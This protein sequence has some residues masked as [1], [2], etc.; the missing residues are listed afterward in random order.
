MASE[1]ADFLKLPLY[2]KVEALKNMLVACATGGGSDALLYRHVRTELM[3]DE[4]LTSLTPRLVRT[5]R[6]PDEFWQFIMGEFSTYAERREFL[7]SEFDPILTYLE[8][9]ANGPLS[10]TA[11][12]ALKSMTDE[13]VADV[14]KR[15]LQRQDTDP[16]GAITAA[17]TLVETV[18][19]HV[20]DD[21]SE[22]YGDAADL[23]AL[24]RSV[25][26][27]LNLAPD[28]HTEQ[29]FRQILGG[30]QS[31]VNGL[32]SVR[33][34]LGDA[35]GKGRGSARPS[36]RHAGLAVNVAGSLSAFIVATW[37]HRK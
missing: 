23:P 2:E 37:M 20:L 8:K 26:L 34:K 10:Q 14:W 12:L 29:A 7:R 33:N 3:A 5:C 32:A 17:R 24:Y 11:D 31:I 25:A 16:E 13:A 19:K 4:T 1:A 9:G 28:Q 6:G 21:L 30:C 18:C 27:K 15:M 35:H 22:P 36:P